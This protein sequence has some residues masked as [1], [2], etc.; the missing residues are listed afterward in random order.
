M[1]AYTVRRLLATI[2]L[3]AVGS[4]VVFWAVAY[5]GDPLARVAACT[6]CDESAYQRI[7]DLYELDRSIPERYLSWAADALSGDLGYSTTVG[8]DVSTVLR[9][10]GWNTAMLALP[11][12]AITAVL[13]V[14]VSVVGAT[15]RHSF[16]DHALTG[17]SY[18]GIAMPTFV[19]ALLLQVFW[20]VWWQEWTGTKPFYVTGKHDG[21]LAELAASAALPIATL[22][23]VSVAAQSRFGR[24]ALVEALDADHVRTARAKGLSWRRVVWRHALRNAMVPLVTVWALDL[25]VLLSGAVVTENVFGWPG[26]GRAL[27]QAIVESD[28]DLVMGVTM[29]SAVLVVVCN[30]VADVLYGILDPRVRYG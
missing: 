14:V 26:L 8:Q 9:Q 20:G 22:V 3:L 10:R 5:A 23:I 6:T 24:A 27:V 16:T 7:I 19:F 30:L 28:L 11:A 18:V 21:S 25:A 29:F 15:R 12:F 4:F 13:S 17:L 1:L 2:P